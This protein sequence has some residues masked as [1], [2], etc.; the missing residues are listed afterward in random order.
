MA[1][2]RAAAGELEGEHYQWVN[3][4]QSNNTLLSTGAESVLEM[5]GAAEG[6]EC[7][8]RQFHGPGGLNVAIACGDGAAELLNAATEAQL[9][10]SARQQGPPTTAYSDREPAT[11]W[12]QEGSCSSREMAGLV[13]QARDKGTLHISNRAPPP[14]CTAAC[15][16]MQAPTAVWPL[17]CCTTPAAHTAVRLT[18]ADAAAAALPSQLFAGARS[19][20]SPTTAR[21]TQEFAFHSAAAR[22]CSGRYCRGPWVEPCLRRSWWRRRASRHCWP[23]LSAQMRRK[24]CGE[25][26]RQRSSGSSWCR[27]RLGVWQGRRWQRRPWQR[28]QQQLLRRT[29]CTAWQSAL[30]VHAAITSR[31]T[32][33]VRFCHVGCRHSAACCWGARLPALGCELYTPLPGRALYV[34]GGS[35]GRGKDSHGRKAGPGW[36][37]PCRR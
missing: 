10:R 9:V 13:G 32:G 8:V 22:P 12:R 24:Q 3:V 2:Q 27:L 33:Q 28:P 37:P 5:L 23:W 15:A 7:A 35:G 25:R 34:T 20:Q 1:V 18:T 6:H 21:A 14:P 17:S 11:T 16:A 36:Q 26:R 30:Q 19:K 29:A 31:S 4:V